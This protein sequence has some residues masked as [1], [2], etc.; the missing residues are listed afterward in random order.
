M[1]SIQPYIMRTRRRKIERPLLPQP[2]NFPEV[3]EAD[4]KQ[5]LYEQKGTLER[6]GYVDLSEEIVPGISR[7][8]LM[9]II[10]R[11]RITTQ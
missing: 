1:L 4:L 7:G 9:F 6:C 5:I 11:K 2:Q 3:D 10:F 8:Q